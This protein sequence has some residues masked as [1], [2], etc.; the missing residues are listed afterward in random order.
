MAVYRFRVTFEDYDDITR[1]IEIK[2]SQTFDD[3]HRAIHKTTGYKIDQ[4]SSFFVSNDFWHKGEEI[5]FMPTESKLERGV[6]SMEGTKVSRFVDD[7]HQKFY[8]IYNFDRPYD[9][10]VELIKILDE[11]K[12]KEYPFI[13]RVEGSA[14]LP[15]GSVVTVADTEEEEGG[16]DFLSETEYGFGDEDTSEMGTVNSVDEL[17][18]TT[19]KPEEE[20][21]EFMDDF[22]E[23]EEFP[24]D[25][26]VVNDDDY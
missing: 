23:G 26:E 13:A 8:Y 9:F 2:S 10:H 19:G 22:N 12:S 11:D 3:L 7:P 21:N 15:P 25:E 17:E 18:G 5:A 6:I 1:D 20:K 24:Q 4:P 16:F 14:P